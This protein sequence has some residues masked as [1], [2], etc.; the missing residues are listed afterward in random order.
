MYYYYKKVEEGYRI[1]YEILNETEDT[2]LDAFHVDCQDSWDVS[3][4]LRDMI[5]H[6]LLG[7]NKLNVM[8]EIKIYC[9]SGYVSKV[10]EKEKLDFAIGEKRHTWGDSP[11]VT[12]ML[13]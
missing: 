5:S 6:E 2:T 13:I 8:V 12:L 4:S 9:P 3:N 11:R 10:R 7:K 1:H